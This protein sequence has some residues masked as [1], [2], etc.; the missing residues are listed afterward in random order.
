MLRTKQLHHFRQKWTGV[1]SIQPKCMLFSMRSKTYENKL[2]TAESIDTSAIPNDSF[3]ILHKCPDIEH[4]SERRR[5]LL[6]FQH[7]LPSNFTMD[8]NAVSCNGRT[9][10]RETFYV[11]DTINATR[12]CYYNL[13]HWSRDTCDDSGPNV[14]RKD[15]KLNAIYRWVIKVDK[16]TKNV[17]GQSMSIGIKTT[18]VYDEWNEYGLYRIASDGTIK[19]PGYAYD[20]STKSPP[21]IDK[22]DNIKDGDIITFE[23]NMVNN[24]QEI[25]IWKND[26][27][28]GKVHTISDMIDF[29]NVFIEIGNCR[30]GISV[31]VLESLIYNPHLH[32]HK[33]QCKLTTADLTIDT[34]EQ[35][36]KKLLAIDETSRKF[37]QISNTN[38]SELER[39][40]CCKNA[41]KKSGFRYDR[42]DWKLFNPCDLL[43]K[44]EREHLSIV[45]EQLKQLESKFCNESKSIMVNELQLLDK[46]M[47]D[48]NDIV[49]PIK[50]G[51]D[52]DSNKTPLLDY[53][54]LLSEIAVLPEK[55]ELQ[56]D[57]NGFVALYDCNFDAN[58][59][60]SRDPWQNYFSWSSDS[61]FEDFHRPFE[62]NQNVLKC[63]NTTN[64]KDFYHCT[65]DLR[66]NEK[67]A[68]VIYRWEIRID[69]IPSADD[70]NSFEVGI[71]VQ[72]KDKNCNCDSFYAVKNDGS[73]QIDDSP[74]QD[75]GENTIENFVAVKNND[76]VTVELNLQ[77]DNISIWQNGTYCGVIFEN[78]KPTT[79]TFD[80][81]F[82][83]TLGN[84]D[85]NNKVCCSML[86]W[87]VKNSQLPHEVGIKFLET[88]NAFK[89]AQDSIERLQRLNPFN[90]DYDNHFID[91]FRNEHLKHIWKALE[92]CDK[93]NL[94]A[95]I[96]HDWSLLCSN[97][98]TLT[99]TCYEY[100]KLN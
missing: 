100:C 4:P 90:N 45:V 82:Y 42:I 58:R 72:A 50:S 26:I 51:N 77:N 56:M 94:I 87:S 54:I 6:S 15:E 86:K 8:K 88:Y 22:F 52:F 18:K 32:D 47:K 12:A 70:Y 78:I 21:M 10:T 99:D 91:T 75:E 24:L 1:A 19:V 29:L 41:H 63:S 80:F 64:I 97:I 84:C 2:A 92:Y 65:R 16:M 14:N 89:R 20:D 13:H 85:N 27:Y 81:S 73:L 25:S 39:A 93:H 9:N 49:S 66:I 38:I 35:L 95:N 37:K 17:N 34:S 57:A 46:N 76:I 23:L 62:T 30:D 3:A 96:I 44:F 83:V 67:S 59:F 31:S 33:L 40:E 68:D 55:D 36:R 69:E 43:N 11:P 53:L 74:V 5:S 28:Y 79:E 71:R 61:K 98:S 7:E 60:S 48:F